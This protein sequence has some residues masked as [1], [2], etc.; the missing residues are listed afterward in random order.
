MMIEKVTIQLGA[1]SL[2]NGGGAGS[3]PMTI[4]L[5]APRDDRT[6]DDSIRGKGLQPPHDD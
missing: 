4:E 6:N 3:P 1:K 2:K 5:K